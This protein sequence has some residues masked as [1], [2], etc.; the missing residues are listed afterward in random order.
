[1]STLSLNHSRVNESGARL[2]H[3]IRDESLRPVIRFL[4]VLCVF[5]VKLLDQTGKTLLIERHE[6]EFFIEPARLRI[7]QM[8]GDV[9]PRHSLF[10]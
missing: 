7:V 8:H 1:M 6:T 9:N 5:V 10:P 2:L 3:N 4:C